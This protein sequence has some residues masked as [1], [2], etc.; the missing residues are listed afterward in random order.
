MPLTPPPPPALRHS[1]LA[2]AGSPP[3]QTASREREVEEVQALAALRLCLKA[4][5]WPHRTR[6]RQSGCRDQPPTRE[7]LAFTP[8]IPTAAPPSEASQ[9]RCVSWRH[10]AATVRTDPGLLLEAEPAG[11]P[12]AAG[13]ITGPPA[14]ESAPRKTQGLGGAR[15]GQRQTQSSTASLPGIAMPRQR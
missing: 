13:D 14:P 6:S 4:V 15:P 12:T 11:D 3:V 1:V 8:I 5:R 10:Q 9:R 2:V 7:H